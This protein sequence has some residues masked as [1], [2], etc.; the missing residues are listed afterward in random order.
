MASTKQKLARIPQALPETKSPV[1]MRIGESGRR[2]TLDGPIKN[3][4][5][6]MRML[7]T[8]TNFLLSNYSGTISAANEAK[9]IPTKNKLKMSPIV[10][11]L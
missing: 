1:A 10:R 9:A 11:V 3:A 2:R 5:I 7:L 4:L 6:A 8:K